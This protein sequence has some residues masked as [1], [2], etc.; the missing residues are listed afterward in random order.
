MKFYIRFSLVCVFLLS[1]SV[2]C[3]GQLENSEQLERKDFVSDASFVVGTYQPKAKDFSAEAAAKAANDFLKLLSEKDRERVALKLDNGERRQWT[4]LP[5]RDSAGGVRLAKMNESQIKAACE[6][7]RSMMSESGYSKMVSIMIA[8]D[9]LLRGGRPRRG[10][11]TEYFSVVI[12]GTP[13]EDSKWGVQLDGHHVGL[14]FSVEKE[15]LT[16]SPS[17]IGSQPTS[18]EIGDKKVSPLPGEIKDAFVLVQSLTDDQRK[19][20]VIRPR[21]VD[22]RSGPGTDGKVPEAKGVKCKDFNDEQKSALLKLIRNWVSNMPKDTAQQR[23]K[24]IEDELVETHFSWNG[25]TKTGSDVSFAIQGPSLIIEYACQ[26][27]GGDP[28][29]HIHTMYRNPKNEYGGQLGK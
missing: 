10:F 27:L 15:K 20:A 23:M 11:G 12:F 7:L 9:Q 25:A 18:Y 28:L 6:L 16:M 26:D 5:A 2:N 24:Q 19:Q 1:I 14:N 4:N 22:L 13:S 3:F 29:Q 21:R 17:F 8:D